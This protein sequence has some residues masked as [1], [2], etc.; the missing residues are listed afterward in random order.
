MAAISFT[1]AYASSM[2][3]VTGM[4]PNQVVYADDLG[5]CAGCVAETNSCWACITTEQQ[6]FS[7]V[8]LTSPVSDGYYMALYGEEFGPA[9]WH[10]VG[11]YPQTAG[12]ENPPKA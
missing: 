1:V 4:T 10:I 8:N 7:D 12:Y 6:V 2:E 5:N 3:A 11:G 9:V